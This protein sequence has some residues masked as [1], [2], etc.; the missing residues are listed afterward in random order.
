[1]ADKTKI[2]RKQNQKINHLN[3]R[4]FL[5]ALV[6]LLAITYGKTINYGYTHFDDDAIIVR[7][8]AYISNISNI[9]DAILR[10]AEFQK[11]SI[12]LYRPFQNISFIF[13]SQWIGVNPNIFHFTN[14]FCFS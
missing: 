6:A 11:Q 9:P 12:E 5:I 3:F 13:D 1:M 2:Q 14:L 4:N 10:D 8:E 7:N